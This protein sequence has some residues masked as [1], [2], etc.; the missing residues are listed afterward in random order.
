MIAAEPVNQQDFWRA[1]DRKNAGVHARTVLPIPCS[2][3]K[4]LYFKSSAWDECPRH[5]FK[6]GTGCCHG[7]CLS[8]VAGSVTVNPCGRFTEGVRKP[9][10]AHNEFSQCTWN[11]CVGAG[12]SKEKSN[13]IQSFSSYTVENGLHA[14][15]YSGGNKGET[16][17]AVR[18]IHD[19]KRE[20]VSL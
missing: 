13:N 6:N 12:D 16:G 3:P 10:Y 5:T 19:M 15:G 4:Q 9:A 1:F 18:C 20:L 14:R 2:C 17:G 7:G 8:Y 11:F